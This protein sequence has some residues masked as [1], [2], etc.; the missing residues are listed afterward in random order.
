M[1][2]PSLIGRVVR[3]TA[4]TGANVTHFELG[5]QELARHKTPPGLAHALAQ[6]ATDT[7]GHVAYFF[8]E[9]FYYAAGELLGGGWGAVF[10]IITIGWWAW[11][12]YH[13]GQELIHGV[14]AVRAFVRKHVDL[15]KRG[16]NQADVPPT[17]P[18]DPVGPLPPPPAPSSPPKSRKK[19]LRTAT[20]NP[21]GRQKAAA[22]G[23]KRDVRHESA[24]DRSNVIPFPIKKGIKG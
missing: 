6:Q 9:A 21:P 14:R 20:G 17:Q 8:S 2:R 15:W 7:W 19:P 23:D 10:L 1:P 16:A 24:L 22:V 11:E 18:P 3:W 13:L 5:I 4:A 12:S